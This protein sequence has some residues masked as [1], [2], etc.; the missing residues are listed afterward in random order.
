[1]G[2]WAEGQASTDPGSEGPHRCQWKLLFKFLIVCDFVWTWVSG[3]KY[4]AIQKFIEYNYDLYGQKR[5]AIGHIW[6]SSG[7]KV[8]VRTSNFQMKNSE[9]NLNDKVRYLVTNMV[10][11]R[12]PIKAFPEYL[13]ILKIIYLA[14]FAHCVWI[15]NV[16]TF[17]HLKTRC[18]CW[19]LFSEYKR[20]NYILGHHYD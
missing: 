8:N 10:Q 4:I 13:P 20:H 5:A 3:L 16:P 14:D 15:L 12:C 2:G 1:M 9:S 7:Q 18:V 19:S 17:D 11:Q 6:A